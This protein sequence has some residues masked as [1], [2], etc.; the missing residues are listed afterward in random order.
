MIGSDVAGRFD[1]VRAAMDERGVDC[2]FLPLGSDL[3]YLT[4][5]SAMALER[6][7][8][9]VLPLDG[10]PV[11]VVPALEAPGVPAGPFEVSRWVDGDDPI[12]VIVRAARRPT[13]AGIGDEARAVLLLELFAHLTDTTF[14]PASRVTAEVRMRKDPVEIATLRS[15]AEAVDRAVA[16]LATE[17]RFVGR[18]ET[19][20]ARDAAE[21]L[22][23]CGHDRALFTIVGSGPDSASPHHDPGDRVVAEGDIVVVDMGG[24]RDGYCSDLTRTFAAGP[25]S[26]EAVAVHAAVAAAQE[27]ARAAVASGVAAGAVDRAARAVI[28]KAGLG[29]RFIHRTG[30][31]I[32]LD[33]H[34]EPYIV[35]GNERLLEPGMVFSLEPGVYLPDR[36]GVRIEDIV[37][38]TETGSETLNRADRSLLA[39]A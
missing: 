19:A 30:H 17:V 36:L 24:A 21:L 11:L 18:A 26:S 8:V 1:R 32:G 3:R 4:G 27:A 28:E 39:V 25:P 7:T 38:V 13:V 31:G 22:V 35:V 9:L 34:E 5:Y 33:I 6:P 23:E 10:D 37:V 15:A 14:I 12:P 2:L 20:I 29:H 16:R